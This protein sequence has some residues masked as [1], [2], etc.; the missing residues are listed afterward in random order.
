VLII[1]YTIRSQSATLEVT[2]AHRER[3]APV[4]HTTVMQRAD[5][6]PRENQSVAR[7]PLT[8]NGRHQ[9]C[10]RESLCIQVSERR[11]THDVRRPRTNRPSPAPP[12]PQPRQPDRVRDLW[13]TPTFYALVIYAE[14]SCQ[15]WLFTGQCK[16]IAGQ[17]KLLYRPIFGSKVAICVGD[18][19]D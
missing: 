15:F 11:F 18:E 14:P 6:V 17:R 3:F 10:R 2:H 16:S 19:F 1:V 12:P 9:K 8:S 7:T 5:R 13:T 4:P